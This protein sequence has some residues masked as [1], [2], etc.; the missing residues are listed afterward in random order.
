M[1]PAKHKAWQTNRSGQ[2]ETSNTSP[3]YQKV[4]GVPHFILGQMGAATWYFIYNKD[5][6]LLLVLE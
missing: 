2:T 3:H 5:I 4:N 6:C 1:K